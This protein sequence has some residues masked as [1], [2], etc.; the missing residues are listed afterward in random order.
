MREQRH[1]HEREVV[2]R[3]DL[4]VEE[5]VVEVVRKSSARGSTTKYANATPAAKS[6]VA[7]TDEDARR[8]AACSPRSPGARKPRA[9]R[10]RS[11]ARS[12]ARR[13]KLTLTDVKNGSV[14]PSVTSCLSSGSGSSQPARSA[15]RGRRTRRMNAAR[16]R[17]SAI[18]EPVPSSPR[19]STSVAS[20]P[21]PRRRGSR[22]QA[23]RGWARRRCRA[24]ACASPGGRRGRLVVSA[25]GSSRSRSLVIVVA[26]RVMESLNSR[27][28]RAERPAHLGQPLGPEDEE[29]D[30]QEDHDLPDTDSEW[31]T[32]T[33]TT[34]FPIPALGA[35]WKAEEQNRSRPAGEARWRP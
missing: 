6:A 7:T 25:G 31:H 11:A 17:P 28:P 24:R 23:M 19:C 9:G 20:S 26:C 5:V 2:A 22:L 4:D 8:R 3:T 15:A 13:M 33:L 35:W 1:A 21:W 10:G 16:A 18:N 27:I 29:H 14:T 12:R 30:E 34:V 32:A